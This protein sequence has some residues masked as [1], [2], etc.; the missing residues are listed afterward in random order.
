MVTCKACNKHVN[1]IY[2][3]TTEPKCENGHP[4]GKW[5]MCASGTSPHVYLQDSSTADCPVCKKPSASEV[6]KGTFVKCLNVSADG[7]KCEAPPYKWLLEG[8]PCFLNHISTIVVEK[9]S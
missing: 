2:L 7:R 6:P 8:P 9:E 3:R 5:T 1:Y 4:L